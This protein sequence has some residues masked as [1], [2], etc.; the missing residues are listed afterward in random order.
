MDQQKQIFNKIFAVYSPRTIK[1]YITLI[2]KTNFTMLT[3]K[4][5]IKIKKTLTL[6]SIKVIL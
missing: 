4:K 5:K 6:S 1:S 3:K 2:Y